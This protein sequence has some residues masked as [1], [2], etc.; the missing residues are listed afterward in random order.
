MLELNEKDYE[1]IINLGGTILKTSREKPFTSDSSYASAAVEAG[2]PAAFEGLPDKVEKI[3]ENYARFG[4]DCLVMLGG[5]G[6]HTTAY[7]LS[8][9]GLNVLG[10]PKTID[11]DIEGTERTF[12]FDS[13]HAVAASA[14]A[15][16]HSTAQSHGRVMVLE[17][18]GNKAGWLTLFAGVSG[19]ADVILIPEIPYD[20]KSIARHIEARAAS[21]K[22]YSIVAVAE[23]ALSVE[24]S[25]MDKKDRK[26]F[27]LETAVPSIAYRVA[28]EIERETGATTRATVL[29]YL[30]RGGE[31]SAADK[32]LGVCMGNHAAALLSS[33]EYGRMVALSGGVMSSVGLDVPAD[34]VRYV[35]QD[36]YVLDTALSL[37]ICIG[38]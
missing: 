16:L 37:G 9:E 6:S 28:S 35:P 15:S 24:E 26:K 22:N 23:G 30:Q 19:A 14:L 18:M 36:H 2:S 5:N 10:I 4:L 32:I 8:Q 38:V 33:G 34:K 7:R 21:G 27:R 12:G 11:N 3:K 20:I 13:A 31:P 25:G 29:G 1:G 17:L